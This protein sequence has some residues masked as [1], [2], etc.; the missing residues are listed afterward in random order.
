MLGG[1]REDTVNTHT[2]PEPA[3]PTLI[4]GHGR[5]PSSDHALTVAADLGRRLGARLHVVHA[6]CL[7]DYPIDPDA[8]DWEEQGAAAVAEERRHVEHLLADAPLQWSHEARR[9]EPAAVLTRAADEYD[10]LMIVVGSRGEGLR[11]ALARL[12]DPSVSHGV[13]GHQ[14]HPVL[15]VPLPHPE[16]G[17]EV[18]Q[19]GGAGVGDPASARG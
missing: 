19:R 4:L 7:E 5:D 11:R 1:T 13:I 15:V 8:A 3:M 18:E 10:A 17:V 14:R 12:A 16:A 2:D 9:G 6:I